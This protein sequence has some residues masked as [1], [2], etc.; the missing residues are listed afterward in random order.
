MGL[1]RRY[2]ALLRPSPQA[3]TPKICF[4]PE[5]PQC[6]SGLHE[7]FAAEHE[8]RIAEHWARA[9]KIMGALGDIAHLQLER[10][11]EDN[12]LSNGVMLTLDEQALGQTAAG[13]IAALKEG[14]LRIWTRGEGN[15]IRV[16]VAHL[17][18]DEIDIL[19]ERLRE[20]LTGG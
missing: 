10:H 20:C 9:D 16:A 11:V 8:A 2:N 3:V 19:I 6:D 14:D 17:V 5:T 4:W 13:V 7:W 15:R 18:G 12:S 1:E